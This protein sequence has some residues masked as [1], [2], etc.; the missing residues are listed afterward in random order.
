MS[1]LISSAKNDFV[2]LAADTK[3]TDVPVG[4]IYFAYDT[5]EKYITYDGTNWVLFSYKGGIGWP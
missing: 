4:S 3:P 2:G 1:V 5:H